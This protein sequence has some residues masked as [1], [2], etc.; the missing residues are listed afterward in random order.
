MIVTPKEVNACMFQIHKWLLNH[1]G[2]I[3]TEADIAEIFAAA[4][5]QAATLANAESAYRKT[6]INPFDP[7]IFTDVDFLPSDVT[8]IP[9]LLPSTSAGVNQ[10]TAVSHQ[11]I[12]TVDLVE[13]STAAGQQTISS[14]DAIQAPTSAGVDQSTTV[15][16]QIISTV[17]LVEP[18]TASGQQTISSMDAIKATTSAG[19]DQSTSVS[20]QII[21]TVDLVQPSTSNGVNEFTGSNQL[22]GGFMDLIPIPKNDQISTNGRIRRAVAH[23]SVVTNSPYKLSLELAKVEKI[24]KLS[25]QSK[26]KQEKVTKRLSEVKRKAMNG[27]EKR[28]RKSTKQVTDDDDT[29]CGHCG[30][31]Y[32]DASA[33]KYTDNW[34]QCGGCKAWLHETCAETC[35]VFDDNEYSC[36]NCL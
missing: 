19:V 5:G 8:D 14:M 35:G 25:A 12:S 22:I 3:V 2:R 1:Q 13:P 15:S 17:D 18:S 11:I 33:A 32:N 31:Q 7:H 21:S 23:A 6:G 30:V 36:Q 4:Y 16:H 28:V 9:L 10:S 29:K 24:K 27:K 34:I 20:H 26:K